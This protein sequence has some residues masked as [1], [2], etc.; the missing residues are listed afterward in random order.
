ML[1]A[2]TIFAT[3]LFHL[4]YFVI[5]ALEN[6]LLHEFFDSV[7]LR[8][9]RIRFTRTRAGASNS[10]KTVSGSGSLNLLVRDRYLHLSS[11]ATL[12]CDC[13]RRRVKKKRKT[14]RK[15]EEKKTRP[16]PFKPPAASGGDGEGRE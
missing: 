2:Y 15:R 14:E 6:R 10:E 13:E 8:I 4:I 7:S 3:S 5:F 9:E 11:K 16:P 1:I 12:R